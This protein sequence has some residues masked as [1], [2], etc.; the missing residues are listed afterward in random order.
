MTTARRGLIDLT[1]YNGMH[2]QTWLYNTPPTPRANSPRARGPANEA[3]FAPGDAS[4]INEVRPCTRVARGQSHQRLRGG[5]VG[6]WVRTRCRSESPI[7]QLPI[8]MANHT[9]S[10][11]VGPRVR[12]PS[13]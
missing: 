2:G 7:S 9:G 4:A 13:A 8:I 12:G 10:V 6:R 11:S 1:S 3:S 5:W